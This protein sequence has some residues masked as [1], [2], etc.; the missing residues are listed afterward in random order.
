MHR[1]TF[2]LAVKVNGKILRENKD[3]VTLP[4]GCEYELVLKNLNSRR[5]MVNVSVDGKDATD[6]RLVLGPNQS[7]TLER[8]INNGNLNAG[9]RFKFIERTPGIEQHRGIKA[10]DGLIRAEFWAEKEN[11]G[12]TVTD[13]ANTLG[14]RAK[15][16][17]GVLLMEGVFATINTVLTPDQIRYVTDHVHQYISGWRP[18]RRKI[19]TPPPPPFSPRPSY[20]NRRREDGPRWGGGNLQGQRSMSPRASAGPTRSRGI[21]GQSVGGFR[22]FTDT[23]SYNETSCSLGGTADA[24]L[25]EGELCRGGIISPQS[26]VNLNDA[27][28]TVPGSESRQQFV[29]V[30]GFELEPSSSVIV[31]QLKGEIAGVAVPVPVTVDLRPVCQ[32]CG[33]RNKGTSQYCSQCGTSLR[34]I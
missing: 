29:H 11:S 5:A 13:L 9:N 25:E 24:G 26:A 21:T 28:I 31:L 12:V 16:V 18:E 1:N 4:F 17:I 15:D 22:S 19:W 20:P 7:I 27:G 23:S 33:R 14:V 30:S 6:G 10:D 34:I 32:T 2:V 8:S 3:I